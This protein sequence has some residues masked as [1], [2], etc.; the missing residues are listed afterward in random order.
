[1]LKHR[2]QPVVAATPHEGDTATERYNTQRPSSPASAVGC[3]PSAGEVP[4]GTSPPA[5]CGL[6]SQQ[7]QTIF[8][9]VAPFPEPCETPECLLHNG[10]YQFNKQDDQKKDRKA[11]CCH[12]RPLMHLLP[13]LVGYVTGPL[14]RC[15]GFDRHTFFVVL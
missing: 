7:G 9:G 4:E 6:H 1:M 14:S 5:G 10:R 2:S 13:S 3:M 12:A 8:P 15:C 11:L